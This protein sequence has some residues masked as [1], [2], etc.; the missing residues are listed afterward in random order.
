MAKRRILV[1]CP[2]SSIGSISLPSL[3]L[4]L[5]SPCSGAQHASA[6]AETFVSRQEAASAGLWRVTSAEVDGHRGVTVFPKVG[7][8]SG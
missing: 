1:P 3:A 7:L 5:L 6:G 8:G 4:A 2:D